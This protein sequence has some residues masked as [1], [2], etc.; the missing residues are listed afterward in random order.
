MFAT[1][2]EKNGHRVEYWHECMRGKPMSLG[3]YVRG[4]IF[5]GDQYSVSARFH[6]TVG[7]LVIERDL[8]LSNLHGLYVDIDSAENLY[9]PAYVQL[10]QDL[11]EGAIRKVFVFELEDLT[12][13]QEGCMEFN[14]ITPMVGGIELLVYDPLTGRIKPAPLPP[15]FSEGRMRSIPCPV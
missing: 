4:E 6:L 3:F 7:M 1:L 11:I 9:R 14:Q 8:G 2:M 5:P 12:M 10:K 13:L 15:L